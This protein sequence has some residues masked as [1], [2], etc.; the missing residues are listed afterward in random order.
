MTQ[1]TYNAFDRVLINLSHALE[2]LAGKPVSGRPYPAESAEN[3]A[4]TARERR[5]AARYMRVNH[6]GEICAQALYQS[7]AL[8]T[9]DKRTREQM[10]TA[11]REE[12][13][14]L[15]WCERRIEELGARKSL[16]N[17]L[18]YAGAFSIGALAGLAGERWNLGFVAET[19]K[20][21][22]RHLEEHLG[23]LPQNDRRSREVVSRMKEDEAHHAESA[24]AAGAAE[25]PAPIKALMKIA[26]TVMTR[27][28]HWI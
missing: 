16:L 6:V 22:V 28:A 19:E 13:D 27:I 2:T 8:T 23:R 11:A 9:R 14:H 3:P 7:Q 25:L 10:Q 1:R 12:V 15:A 17:P 24:I 18:W 4:L 26:S 5:N 20:Q 21:V